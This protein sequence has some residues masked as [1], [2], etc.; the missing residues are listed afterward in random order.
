MGGKDAAAKVNEGLFGAVDDL[1][2]LLDED[3]LTVLDFKTDRVSP[4]REQEAAARYKAQV[5][6]YGEAL[7]R[8][9]SRPVKKRLLYFFQTG[10]FVEI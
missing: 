1:C 7:C 10:V 6:A 4:G 8:I 2:C 3:G 9:W 5:L